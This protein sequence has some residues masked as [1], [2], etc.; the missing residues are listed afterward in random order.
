MGK[1]YQVKYSRDRQDPKAGYLIYDQKTMWV[2]LKDKNKATIRKGAVAV[3]FVE[4]L[5][6][7][8][9]ISCAGYSIIILSEVLIPTKSTCQESALTNAL[10]EPAI[11]D[12]VHPLPLSRN[13]ENSTKRVFLDPSL[14]R[15]MRKYQIE[16]A[17]FLLRRLQNANDQ[18]NSIPL[19]G[20]ILADEM[21]TGKTLSAL[22]A[23]SALCSDRSTKAIVVCPSS[24]VSNWRKEI[25]KW[26]PHT[27][28]FS[29]LFI[30]GGGVKGQVHI[31]PS[32]THYS[33]SI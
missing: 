23:I 29:A 16:A 15:V 27:L 18:P 19:T 32:F 30:K 5:V 6:V 1:L 14:M 10:T 25:Q 17:E 22:A 20:A 24:L 4:E 3:D 7:G 28:S 8:K 2:W 9:T 31:S 26:F 11:E 13:Q 21:G 12:I 33:S